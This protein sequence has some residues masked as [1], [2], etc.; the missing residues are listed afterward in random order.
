MQYRHIDRE[1]VNW[2]SS[3][4]LWRNYSLQIEV[5]LT[6]KKPEVKLYQGSSQLMQVIK[7]MKILKLRNKKKMGKLYIKE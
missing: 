1:F 6:F 7:M 3:M 2:E 4:Y 5:D